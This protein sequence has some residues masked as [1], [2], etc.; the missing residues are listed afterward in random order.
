MRPIEKLSALYRM[1]LA[2]GQT[3]L[4]LTKYRLVLWV[5]NALGGI[6]S[7]ALFLFF[8]ATTLFLANIGLAF[9][10]GDYFD[11][12]FTGFFVLSGL[13]LV[14]GLIYLLF[15]RKRCAAFVTNT[16]IKKILQK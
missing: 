10:L 13:Y 7:S 8:M 11:S 6:L 5:S 15:F 2:Y 3:T 14:L 12:L 4:D 16:L 9:W 1:L